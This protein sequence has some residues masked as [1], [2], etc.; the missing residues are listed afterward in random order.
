MS[1]L[2]NDAVALKIDLN[3]AAE[4]KQHSVLSSK[5]LPKKYLY[6]RKELMKGKKNRFELVWKIT[7]PFWK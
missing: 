5:S 4:N 1:Y 6:Q 3:R 7:E 2:E